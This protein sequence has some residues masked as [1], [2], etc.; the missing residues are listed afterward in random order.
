MTWLDAPNF[1]PMDYVDPWD[2]QSQRLTCDAVTQLDPTEDHP[3]Q[4][5][6][7]CNEYEPGLHGLVEW[8][9][10]S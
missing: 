7:R 9:L 8:H 1:L 10:G 2:P 6:A 5:H 4:F 3:T